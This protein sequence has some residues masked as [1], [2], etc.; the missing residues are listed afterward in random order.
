M[1]G[2]CLRLSAVD[3]TRLP[4]GHTRVLEVY[5]SSSARRRNGEI[6]A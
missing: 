3:S 1:R 5:A 4:P 2:W 6:Y